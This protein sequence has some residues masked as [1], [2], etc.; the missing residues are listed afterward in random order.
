MK[1]ESRRW[2]RPAYIGAIGLIAMGI[3]AWLAGA[4]QDSM[5]NLP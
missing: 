1:I 4:L 3:G 2:R 5:A